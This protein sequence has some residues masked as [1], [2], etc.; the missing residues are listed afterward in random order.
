MRNIRQLQTIVFEEMSLLPGVA[1]RACFG[2]QLRQN[3]AKFAALAR[4]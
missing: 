4:R 3:C 1:G 2:E